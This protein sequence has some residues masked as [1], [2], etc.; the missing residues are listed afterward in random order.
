[1]LP[2]TQQGYPLHPTQSLTPHAHML[3]RCSRVQFFVT[4]WTIA[5]QTPLSMR[6]SRQEYW[7]GLP[8]SLPG[9]LPNPEIEP[10]SP[11]S[12]AL[13]GRFFTAEPPGK[14]KRIHKEMYIRGHI[15]GIGSQG[16][17]EQEAPQSAI[18][19][20]ETQ[21]SQWCQWV[22]LWR[23]ENEDGWCPQAGED[24]APAQAESES[25]PFSH[26][27]FPAGPWLHWW[28]PRLYWVHWLFLK[29]PPRHNQK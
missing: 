26:F 2:S 22:W 20:L 23:P 6:F 3:S 17:K 12:P 21:K 15:T 27:L 28:R 19:K 16:Y 14:P 9:D 13:P 29:H 11:A 4:L 24:D 10:M 18:C 5:C 8:F 25:L 1:M 7:S